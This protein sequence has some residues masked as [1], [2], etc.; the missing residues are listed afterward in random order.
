MIEAPLPTFT[1][2]E[3]L[4]EAVESAPTDER[5]AFTTRELAKLWDYKSLESVRRQMTF[6][7]ENKGW[8]FVATRKS[9]VNRAD[10]LTSKSA[11]IVVP[12]NGNGEENSKDDEEVVNAG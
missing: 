6:L 7:E 8:R 11:Y 3:L 2:E 1:I 9:F 4:R 10:D 12:P 5:C